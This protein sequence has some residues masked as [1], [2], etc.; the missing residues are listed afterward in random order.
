MTTQWNPAKAFV[1]VLLG[2][3]AF[4]ALWALVG[5][6]ELFLAV[7]PWPRVSNPHFPW[8]VLFLQWSLTLAAAVVFIGGYFLRW[9]GLPV[10]MACVYAAMAALCAVE[11]FG[12]MQSDTRFV[13]MALEYLAYAGILVFL[14]QSHLFRSVR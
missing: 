13:A 1:V 9:R 2:I 12:Y 7:P 11:T 8:L 3:H 6:A 10:A 5:C 14:F 4:L